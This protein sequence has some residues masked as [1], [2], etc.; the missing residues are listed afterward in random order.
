L[1]LTV[2]SSTDGGTTWTD[3]NFDQLRSN[4]AEGSARMVTT[5]EEVGVLY[6]ADDALRWAAQESDG[7]WESQLLLTYGDE[8]A[9]AGGS[10]FS[11]VVDG[12]DIYVATND[13]D[14]RLVFLSYDGSTGEW[15]AAVTLTDYESA[16]YMEIGLS[17]DGNIYIAFDDREDDILRVLESTDGGDSFHD[18]AELEFAPGFDT[19]NPRMEMPSYFYGDLPVLQQVSSLTGDKNRLVY[20]DVDVPAG[21]TDVFA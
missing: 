4:V 1:A 12:D 10:H 6:T 14:Q 7:D 11:A 2:K 20:Y 17:A 3:E 15:G 5:S 19:G 16:S 18:Y 13:G 21:V 9:A 8:Q